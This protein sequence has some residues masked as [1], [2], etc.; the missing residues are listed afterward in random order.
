MP[1]QISK[2][3]STSE[4]FLEMSK[5][6]TPILYYTAFTLGVQYMVPVLLQATKRIFASSALSILTL[7]LPVPI[8]STILYF[9]GD[10][11]ANPRRIFFTYT[12]ND[13]YSFVVCILFFIKPFKKIV[14]AIKTGVVEG[15]EEEEKPEEEEE[16]V[17][18]MDQ[19]E[20]PADEI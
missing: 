20:R 4:S 6:I 10:G 8:F 1:V 11:K 7:V 19:Q 9:T 17:E 16:S 18:N 2:L 3:W 5:A 12:C 13:M 15:S 14:V